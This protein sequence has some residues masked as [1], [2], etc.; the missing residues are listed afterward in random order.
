MLKSSSDS[1]G[2]STECLIV[3]IKV[4][5]LFWCYTLLFIMLMFDSFVFQGSSPSL[6]SVMVKSSSDSV[7]AS[8]ECMVVSIRMKYAF[9]YYV[10]T[11]NANVWFVRFA[12]IVTISRQCYAKE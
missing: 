9:W 8:T 4:K 1:V 5:Y 11:Y 6:D 7:G 3:S 2:A 12:G 10:S